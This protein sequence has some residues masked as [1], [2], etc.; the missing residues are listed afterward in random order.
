[1]PR[2]IPIGN[3]SLLILYD[4]TGLVRELCFPSVGSENH[5][6]GHA[7]RV[8]VWANGAFSWIDG[9]GWERSLD[10]ED[11][12]LV[13]RIA[14][15]NKSLG[16]GITM[17]DVVDFHENLYVREI[18]AK[19]LTPQAIELRLFFHHDFHIYGSE[20]GDTACFK[21]EQKGLLHYKGRRYFFIN[22]L[23][24]KGVGVDQFATGIKE[25]KGLS[26]T[27]VDAE[28]GVL[29][30]NPVSQG[31]V[32]SVCAVHMA[33]PPHG[34]SQAWYWI[35][36]CVDWKGVKRLNDLIVRR[37]PGHF[38]ARTA[39]YWRLWLDRDRMKFGDLPGAVTRLYTRS[40]LILR[41][42]ISDNGAVIAANDSDILQ[43]SRDTYAYMWPRD[44]ALAAHALDL[45][46]FPIPAQK[47][48]A[49]CGE[50]VGRNGFFMHKYNPDGS[51]ASSWHPWVLEG[52][53]HLPIQEDETGLVLWALWEHYKLYQDVEFIKPLYRKV[54]KAGADFLCDFADQ[55]TW[56][57]L[58]SYDL[59]EER[60]GI[61]TFTTCAVIAGLKAAAN[62][63]SA[64]GE[65]ELWEK[66]QAAADR[67][68]GALEEHLFDQETGRF[69]NG[70]SGHDGSPQKDLK[71]D[72]SLCGLFA[73]GVF[74]ASDEKVVNT[75][76]ALK[77]KLWCKTTLGGL[78][79]YELDRYQS[80]AAPSPDIP[81]NPW[82]IST[83]W[84]AQYLVEKA[85]T[86]TQL[87]ES[88][89]V[90]K[91]VT[92]RALRSGVL[93][94]Q[95]DPLSGE[96]ISVSP[97]VWSHAAF[98]IAVQQYLRKHREVERCPTCGQPLLPW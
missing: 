16:L 61:H 28:D 59:W 77:E 35:A 8:G 36:A 10:Y 54:I 52:R 5:A 39:D 26:G 62:F 53:P 79:R 57:P 48:F 46:G 84:Y 47:F 50:I 4:K 49:F 65:R 15:V 29:S 95:V 74:P 21:P 25:S 31:S 63:T 7:F 93:A 96:A 81:G 13:A 97:L 51:L 76:E 90:L 40:L 14:L 17:R 43:F 11:D 12:T 41:T 94:E 87:R 34:T 30:G 20:I 64:L 67:F 69:M 86:G 23:T 3:G 68:R 71:L 88:I 38:I 91:W 32:D 80:A 89:G 1:M 72:S 98:I 37:T 60:L 58:P 85:K 2:D 83:L 55:R 33:I 82:I 18:S 44:G 56:L 19:N 92:D 45:A 22:A 42:H 6:Q 75:I 70:I 66:Y 78:A 73:F 27:W 24:E 9:E